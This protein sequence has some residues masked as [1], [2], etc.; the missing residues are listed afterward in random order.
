MFSFFPNQPSLSEEDLEDK[1][2][3]QPCSGGTKRVEGAMG[4]C[5]CRRRGGG[6]EIITKTARSSGESRHFEERR[7]SSPVVQSCERFNTS[8]EK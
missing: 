3:F 8:E 1:T 7:E 2:C 4:G 6:G 5:V